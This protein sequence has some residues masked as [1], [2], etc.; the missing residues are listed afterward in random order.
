[1]TMFKKILSIILT[2]ALIV[3]AAAVLGSCGEEPE[4]PV[5]IGNITIEEEPQNIVILDKNLADII[6]AIGYDVK[7]V[8][9]SDDVNQKGLEVV[10]SMGTAHDPSVTKII[11]EKTDIVFTGSELNDADV[12][13]LKKAGI[14]VAQFEKANTI[15]Q[16]KSLYIKIGTMLG[17]NTEGKNAATKVYKEIKDTL[18][19]V[20]T[21]AK[22]DKTVSTLVYLYADNG[23]MK[24]ITNG[25]WASTLLGYTGSMNV[26]DSADSDVVDIDK[27]LLADPNYIFV[28]DK[29]VK[30]Y[31]ETSDVLGDLNALNDRTFIIPLDELQL[32]GYTS[33][34]VLE[35][36]ISDITSVDD[37]EAESGS[38]EENADEYT[39]EGAE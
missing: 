32:Q 37:N 16:L 5:K 24:T 20:K 4:F 18:K 6:S 9:R 39:E 1:M 34:D 28:A 7:M 27:L 17:G 10:P 33:L 38:S 21:A 3:S 35:K 19:A 30:K 12:A 15:K 23:V 31:L 14:V 29:G 22:R 2:G 26:F 25:S 36:I 13:K 8:G 11:K